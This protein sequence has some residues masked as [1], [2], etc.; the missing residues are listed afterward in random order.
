MLIG[1]PQNVMLGPTEDEENLSDFIKAIDKAGP[2]P[3][4]IHSRQGSTSG[5]GSGIRESGQPGAGSS[6]DSSGL[7]FVNPGASSGG[8]PTPPRRPSSGAFERRRSP[9]VNAIQLPDS[10]LEE[11]AE[12]GHDAGHGREGPSL[13]GAARTLLAPGP[14]VTTQNDLD[15]RLKSM[16]ATFADSIRGLRERRRAKVNSFDGSNTA[17]QAINLGLESSTQSEREGLN[18]KL[19]P[20]RM[21]PQSPP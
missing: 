14:I 12:D 15:E 19:Y 1:A 10:D 13:V 5:T 6:S 18:A 7:S 20:R 2:L 17:P 16:D 21:L 4:T 8:R 9:L 3:S 11:G